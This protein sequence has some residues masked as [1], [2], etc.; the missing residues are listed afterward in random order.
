MRLWAVLFGFVGIQMAW[1]LRPFL[2]DRNQPFRLVGHYQGNFYEAVIY[3]VKQ[4]VTD[5]NSTVAPDTS[6]TGRSLEE[7]LRP[8]DST[9]VPEAR[10]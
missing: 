7:L 3:A 2:G 9:A 10:R 4:L 6:T 8:R 5:S 1:N